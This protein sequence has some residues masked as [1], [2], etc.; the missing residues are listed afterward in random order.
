M[1]SLNVFQRGSAT[2]PDHVIAQQF[3][4][5]YMGLLQQVSF[6]ATAGVDTTCTQ[7]DYCGTTYI[8]SDSITAVRS[9]ITTAST[10]ALA[11]VQQNGVTQLVVGFNLAN[12]QSIQ[13]ID[14]Y[15]GVTYALNSYS[16]GFKGTQL[17]ISTTNTDFAA[18]Q[19]TLVTYGFRRVEMDLGDGT[20]RTIYLNMN[21]VENVIGSSTT[22]YTYV[23][24]NGSQITDTSVAN[25]YTVNIT[26]IDADDTFTDIVTDAGTLSMGGVFM[27]TGGQRTAIKVLIDDYLL[28]LGALSGTV[29]V[30]APDGTT[31]RI[32]VPACNVAFNTAT[33]VID[34]VSTPFTFVAT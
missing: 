4:P 11:G 28:S 2:Y 9:A 15:A 24:P 8:V 29:A 22:Y 18:K 27:T 19:A 7:F 10:I 33:A 26:G 5:T 1:I 23:L 34:T 3:N 16:V 30:T 6:A 12:V 17:A 20:T 13:D 31:L 21:A 25:T 32:V 14:G